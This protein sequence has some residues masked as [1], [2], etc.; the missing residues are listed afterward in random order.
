LTQCSSGCLRAFLSAI[1]SG[2]VP[3]KGVLS[4]RFYALSLF[5]SVSEY[6]RRLRPCGRRSAQG[7]A[8]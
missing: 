3:C 6:A 5:W 1:C 7:M 4:F 8:L 2:A